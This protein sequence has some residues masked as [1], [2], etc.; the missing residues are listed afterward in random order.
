VTSTMTYC[1]NF[2]RAAM[3]I[4]MSPMPHV[5]KNYCKLLHVPPNNNMIIKMQKLKTK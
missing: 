3:V 1:K 2:W 5:C 4:T